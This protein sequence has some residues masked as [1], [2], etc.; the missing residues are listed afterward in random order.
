MGK[1]KEK[2]LYDAISESKAIQKLIREIANNSTDTPIQKELSNIEETE[3]LHS[4]IAQLHTQLR[5]ANAE[6]E[7]YK[8]SYVQVTQKLKEYDRLKNV[9]V[10]PFCNILT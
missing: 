1:L 3:K 4:Q 9:V 6:L 8:N 10:N 2:E 5:Q 7:Q